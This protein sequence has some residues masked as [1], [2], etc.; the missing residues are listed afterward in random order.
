MC[1]MACVCI[2]Q[3]YWKQHNYTILKRKQTEKW[4]KR[5][6][7]QLGNNKLLSITAREEERKRRREKWKNERQEEETRDGRSTKQRENGRM[8]DVHLHTAHIV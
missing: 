5:R 7:T 4:T 1:D 6:N 3:G 8:E 2:S